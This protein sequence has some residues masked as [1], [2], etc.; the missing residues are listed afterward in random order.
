MHVRS[1]PKMLHMDRPASS[2][3]EAQGTEHERR[4]LAHPPLLSSGS[5]LTRSYPEASQADQRKCQP[6]PPDSFCTAA[7][8]PSPGPRGI[9]TRGVI[10][11]QRDRWVEG[12]HR[13]RQLVREF[14][15]P[16]KLK[17]ESGCRLWVGTSLGKPE[18]LPLW[19]GTQPEEDRN[20]VR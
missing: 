16:R 11:P 15:G 7:L 6:T 2:I 20:T 5:C 8:R 18:I 9:Y 10:G 3:W 19:G 13:L 14:Q 17:Q 1:P 12:L 4:S